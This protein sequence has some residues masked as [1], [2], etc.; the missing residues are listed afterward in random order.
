VVGV[1]KPTGIGGGIVLSRQP[2]DAGFGDPLLKR[3]ACISREARKRQATATRAPGRC[4]PTLGA[5]H[6][7]VAAIPPGLFRSQ[8]LG[9][10]GG[11]G[12]P[13]WRGHQDAAASLAACSAIQSATSSS[14]ATTARPILNVLG[15]VPR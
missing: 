13:G 14:Y 12:G 10:G 5:L 6:Q 3:R 1:G 9:T 7:D 4:Y 11:P 8:V 15:P 2:R